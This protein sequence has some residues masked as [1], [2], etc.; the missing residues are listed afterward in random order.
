MDILIR[1]TGGVQT[2]DAT[3]T[4]RAVET[5]ALQIGSAPDQELQLIGADILPEHAEITSSNKGARISCR[6]GA[7]V[8]VNGKEGRKFDLVPNDVI[9]VGGNRIEVTGAPSGFDLAHCRQQNLRGGTNSLRASL[10]NRSI[11]NKTG[12]EAARLGLDVSC[13]SGFDDHT[14]R[15][16][17]LIEIG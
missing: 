11:S 5:T 9:E 8:S 12:S 17:L 16:S 14:A 10:Q 13:A 6:R 2:V 15:L 7:L 3:F 1:Q 4:D